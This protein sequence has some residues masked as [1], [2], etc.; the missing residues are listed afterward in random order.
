M[1]FFLLF[2]LSFV[3]SW[4]YSQEIDSLDIEFEEETLSCDDAINYESES[5]KNA[6]KKGL[7]LY[8]FVMSECERSEDLYNSRNRITDLYENA[9][10]LIFSIEF[11]KNC[12]G[13]AL[14]SVEIV[15]SATWNFEIVKVDEECEECFCTCCFTT[16]IGIKNNT[17][18]K[19]TDFLFNGV[20]LPISDTLISAKRE[21][22]TFWGNGNLRLIENFHY[23]VLQY[24]VFYDEEGNYLRRVYYDANGNV[25]LVREKDYGVN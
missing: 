23:N 4:G 19:P 11:K 7:L 14:I 16:V 18:F 24:R 5:Y 22:Q 12:C 15:D 6:L 3:I 13:G 2:S 8:D 20:K 25:R 21:Q 1:K 9:D 17:G 10:T